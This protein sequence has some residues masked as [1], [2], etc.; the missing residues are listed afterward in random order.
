MLAIRRHHHLGG[1]ITHSY[2]VESGGEVK[3]S[4]REILE[5]IQR[6]GFEPVELDTVYNR[7]QSVGVT[8]E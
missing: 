1:E 2:S 7:V 8:I 6:E 3:M 4:K 5:M